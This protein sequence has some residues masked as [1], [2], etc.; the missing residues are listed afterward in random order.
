VLGELAPGDAGDAVARE[1]E[2]AV[3]GAVLFEGAAR[4]V[5]REAVELGDE[6]LLRPDAV[7]LLARDLVVDVRPWQAVGVEEGRGS[8][9]RAP[10][11]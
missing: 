1:E 10:A 2:R 9:A 4:A 6:L 7:D 11:W 5:G 8:G 3:A